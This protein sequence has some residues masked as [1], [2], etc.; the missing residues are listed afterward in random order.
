MKVTEKKY[1]LPAI[2][3]ILG[4]LPK[5]RTPVVV[6]DIDDTLL[7]GEP[8]RIIQ[9]IHDFYMQLRQ[10]PEVQIYFITAREVSQE[11]IDFTLDELKNLGYGYYNA[12]YMC[13]LEKQD[14][15]AAFKYDCRQSIKQIGKPVNLNVGNRFSDLFSPVELRKYAN[16]LEKTK[17]TR[18]Y[19]FETPSTIRFKLPDCWADKR[20][21]KPIVP[22]KIRPSSTKTRTTNTRTTNTRTKAKTS[23]KTKTKT[24]PKTKTTT[25][26]KTRTKTDPRRKSKV[27]RRNSSRKKNLDTN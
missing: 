6:F 21:A 13:P 27:T 8:S 15:Q 1:I 9:P 12:L 20:R 19:I 23:I 3:Y 25:K 5:Y 11:N 14:Y 10:I 22:V 26:A 7:E 4:I 16:I 24:K 17:R 2:T 18:F